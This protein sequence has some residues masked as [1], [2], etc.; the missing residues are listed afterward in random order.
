MNHDIRLGGEPFQVVG[1]MPA[2]FKFIWNNVDLWLPL[3]FTAEQKS[4]AA[5]HSNSYG[6]IGLLAPDA[7]QAQAQAQ[8][9]AINAANDERFPAFRQILHDAGFHTVVVP[10]QADLTREIR[11]DAL[12]A[13]GRRAL[14]PAHRLREHRQPRADP[15]QRPRAR[16]GHAPRDWR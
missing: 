15:S 3:P 7:T 14:R 9:D 1:I 11:A 2:D 13:L 12:P 10:L 6:E 5:R 8:V 16:A 4:D